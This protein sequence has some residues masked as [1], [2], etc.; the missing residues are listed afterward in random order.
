VRPFHRITLREKK[1]P[2]KVRC[3]I[4]RPEETLPKK[5]ILKRHEV[6][7][8]REKKM[9]TQE[10]KREERFDAWRGQA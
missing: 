9:R 10:L 5:S 6:Q 8:G 3:S 1:I 4:G 2:P 7:D